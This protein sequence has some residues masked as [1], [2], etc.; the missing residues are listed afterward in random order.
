MLLIRGLGMGAGG[1]GVGVEQNAGSE[2]YGM[3]S[4]NARHEQRRS[5]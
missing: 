5:S 2:W 3:C 1:V 4:G